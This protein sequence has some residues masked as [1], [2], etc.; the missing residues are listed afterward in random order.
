MSYSKEKGSVF[1]C[2]GKRRYA[3]LDYAEQKAKEL[4]EKYSKPLRVYACGICMGYHCTS[5]PK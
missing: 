5:K 4:T 2:V 3:T 1:Q